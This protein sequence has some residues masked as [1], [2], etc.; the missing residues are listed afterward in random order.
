M[1]NIASLPPRLSVH[2]EGPYPMRGDPVCAEHSGSKGVN[3]GKQSPILWCACRAYVMNVMDTRRPPRG[4][5]ALPSIG[6]VLGALYNT[7][8][9]V[10]PEWNTW[11]QT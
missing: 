4:N 10:G 3:L 6:A 2:G 5:I 8:A 11:K 7:P 9:L 1:R